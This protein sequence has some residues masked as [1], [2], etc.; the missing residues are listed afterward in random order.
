MIS[1][2]TTGDRITYCRS[3]LSMT[4][5]ELA[6]GWQG[7]S[8]PTLSRWE[9]DT[10]A[11]PAKKLSSLTDYF[12]QQGLLVTENWLTTGEG[13]PPVI[14]NESGFDAIDFDAM[15]EQCLLDINRRQYNFCFGKVSNNLMA[16]LVKYGDYVGGVKLTSSDLKLLEDEVVFLLKGNE[17]FVGMLRSENGLIFLSGLKGQNETLKIESYDG[18]GKLQWLVRRP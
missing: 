10:V 7:A 8:I 4:R 6:E 17:F 2:T 12:N 3:S 14:L 5:K 11:I 15:A 16:P 1:L 18:I 13:I 9:L